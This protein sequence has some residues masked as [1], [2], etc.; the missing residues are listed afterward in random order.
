MQIFTFSSA[1]MKTEYCLRTCPRYR[2]VTGDRKLT[3]QEPAHFG[4]AAARWNGLRNRGESSVPRVSRTPLEQ[5]PRS[6]LASPVY[7]RGRLRASRWQALS[8]AGTIPAIRYGKLRTPLEQ[9]RR[10]VMTNS[11]PCR[12]R[13]HAPCWQAPSPVEDNLRNPLESSRCATLA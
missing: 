13:L 12:G 9:P 5:P 8:P 11:V 3:E 2:K 10:F 4:G 6:V 1:E 7:C